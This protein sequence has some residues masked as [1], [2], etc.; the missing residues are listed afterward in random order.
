[1][2]KIFLE[3]KKFFYTKFL[4]RKY[5]RYGKCNRCGRCCENIYVRH[6]KDVIKTE[7]EFEKIKS[8]DNYSFYKH[9]TITG[10]DEFGLKFTCNRFDKEKRIC[11]AHNKR[12]SICRNY[13]NEEIFSFGAQLLDE[14]GYKFEPIISFK[15]ILQKIKNKEK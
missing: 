1:M 12:P 13:P 11:K 7:E 15:E 14:C 8:V 10:K 9:I 3:I 6:I 4:K 2:K 5:Y